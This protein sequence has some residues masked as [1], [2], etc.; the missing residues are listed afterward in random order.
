MKYLEYQNEL[1]VKEYYIIM[2]ESQ[3]L[4]FSLA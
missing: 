3:L 4:H 1:S 2:V